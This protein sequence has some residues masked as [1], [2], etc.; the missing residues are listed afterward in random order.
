M[1]ISLPEGWTNFQGGGANPALCADGTPLALAADHDLSCADDI[2]TANLSWS[3]G[4]PPY[5][6]Q[7]S[8]GLLT[9]VDTTHG[10]LKI[11]AAIPVIGSQ[12]GGIGTTAFTR[13]F[14][15]RAWFEPPCTDSISYCLVNLYNCYGQWIGWTAQTFFGHEL[16]CTEEFYPM[17]NGRRRFETC[18]EAC[19]EPVARFS[20]TFLPPFLEPALQAF[21]NFCGYPVTLPDGIDHIVNVCNGFTFLDFPA[22]PKWTPQGCYPSSSLVGVQFKNVGELHTFFDAGDGTNNP[23]GFPMGAA[24]LFLH[25]EDGVLLING[26]S[27]EGK[28]VV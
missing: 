24:H 13:Q 2:F 19:E 5:T 25:P 10:T 1:T 12:C 9:I 26:G 20:C 14:S 18:N 27:L 21:A 8:G 15:T 3:G 16:S 11:D 28:S 4:V 7:A 23:T 22:M 17:P 6:V